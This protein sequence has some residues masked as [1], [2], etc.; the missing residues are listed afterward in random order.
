MRAEVVV[1][2]GGVIGLSV[3]FFAAK[4]T[5]P[6]R[7]PVML[8]ERDAPGAG[9]SGRSTALLW[10]QDE[11]RGVA[12]MARDSLR[13]YGD[14]QRHTGRSLGFRAVGVLT[15]LEGRGPSFRAQA[16]ERLRDLSSFGI[17]LELLGSAE[18]R[19]RFPMLEAEDDALAVWE[20]DAGYLDA[21]LAIEAGCALARNAGAVVRPGAEASALLVEG[22]RVVG[23]ELPEGRVETRRVVV[24]T[25]PWSEELLAGV[26][27]HLPLLTR[28]TRELQIATPGTPEAALPAAQPRAQGAHVGARPPFEPAPLTDP[29]DFDRRFD[30]GFDAQPMG[31]AHPVLVDRGLDLVAHCEPA[32]RRTYVRR[33]RRAGE[34]MA[35]PDAPQPAVEPEFRAWARGA[36]E[37]RLPLYRGQPDLEAR[38]GWTTAAPDGRPVVGA[39]PGIEG[40]YV[41]TGFGDDAFRLAP[42]IGEGLA[43]ELRGQAVSAYDPALFSPARFQ[44]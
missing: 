40:L 38:A 24:A 4:R 3:A 11:D 30:D 6:L 36:L 12:R 32:R 1:V 23:V 34:P 28:R 31:C 2:G 20:P 41:A 16:E 17:R 13:Y 27:V 42:A 18:L 33:L 15:L 8:L 25:G 39:V 19:E 21:G 43:Q 14:F 37:R 35:D 10:Q 29:L 5:D 9:A 26:G 44:G 7:E 22:G